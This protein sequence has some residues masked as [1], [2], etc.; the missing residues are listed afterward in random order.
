MRKTPAG[1][2]AA[3]SSTLAP[4]LIALVVEFAAGQE[5]KGPVPLEAYRREV[6]A[7]RGESGRGRRLF[8]PGP[9][10]HDGR[11]HFLGG[12]RF[13]KRDREQQGGDEQSHGAA[14]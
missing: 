6:L 8:E 1:W 5:P 9:R 11:R 14:P 2:P 4:V 10:H 3:G 12:S 7:A 13:L